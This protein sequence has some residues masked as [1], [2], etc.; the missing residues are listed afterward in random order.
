[1]DNPNIKTYSP[2][3][4]KIK[5]LIYGASGSGKTYF[6]GTAKNALYLSAE[7]GLLSIKDKH[8]KFWE[9]K[10][11][12]DLQKAFLYLQNEEHGFETV[13][14]DSLTEISDI[15]KRG[16]EKE[17]GRT[18]QIQDW[19]T[20]KTKMVDLFRN[21]RDLP[22]HVVFIAL[23]DRI[24]D[25]EK[26]HKIVPDLDGK[27]AVAALPQFIDIVGYTHVEA[28]GRYWIQT[29]GHKKYITKNRGN[30]IGDDCP[31]DFE[32]W[33]KRVQ[34]GYEII[35]QKSAKEEL[36]MFMDE[37]KIENIESLNTILGTKLKDLNLTDKQA[38]NI[39]RQLKETQ[40]NLPI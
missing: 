22:M 20:I 12:N 39:I 13:V 29:N 10:T 8:P 37:M 11:F 33:K 40:A 36:R 9:I 6:S 15:V 7:N 23:D 26:I 1:M 24:V 3:D 38:E 17:N 2:V 28:D 30:V 32:I 5:A 18:M 25:E 19:G 31:P 34:E 16:I 35:P 4:H 27:G 14:L 21:F